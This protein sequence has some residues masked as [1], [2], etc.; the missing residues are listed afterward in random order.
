[1]PIVQILPSDIR[2]R[3]HIEF[4]ALDRLVEYLKSADDLTAKQKVVDDLT[5]RMSR[6]G[7]NLEAAVEQNQPQG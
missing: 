4:P 2:V 6:S 3:F 1:M 7:E 5:A